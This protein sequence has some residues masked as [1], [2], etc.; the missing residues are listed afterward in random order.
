M[1]EYSGT[2]LLRAKDLNNN[3][4]SASELA[5]F[6]TTAKA[7]VLVGKMIEAGIIDCIH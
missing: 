2:K 4:Y 1:V 3:G 6:S 7:F 5:K